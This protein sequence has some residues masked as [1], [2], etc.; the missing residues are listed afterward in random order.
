MAPGTAHARCS[1]MVLGTTCISSSELMLR[2][3][4]IAFPYVLCITF[5][6]YLAV[7]LSMLLLVSVKNTASSPH[8]SLRS[9]VSFDH[10]VVLYKTE[11]WVSY[12]TF[13]GVSVR[14]CSTW[15]SCVPAW[16]T[17]SR[18]GLSREGA[19]ATWPGLRF[20]L[21]KLVLPF[22]ERTENKL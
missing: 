15:H 14:A 13:V 4:S 8:I 18:E 22:R 9:P 5:I 19:T 17:G 2:R 16:A 1:A 7:P 11:V 21:G 12:K 6:M 3:Q 20:Q 10:G